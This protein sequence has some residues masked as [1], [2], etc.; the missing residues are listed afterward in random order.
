MFGICVYCGGVDPHIGECE[1]KK[2]KR[3][4]LLRPGGLMRCCIGT[5]DESEVEEVEGAT[6]KC[7]HC[8]DSL[9]FRDGAWECHADTSTA[10]I[11]KV[12]VDSA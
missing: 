4:L 5:L 9:V 7:K 10:E 1:G 6:L 12:E 3:L 2:M 8:P 11:V